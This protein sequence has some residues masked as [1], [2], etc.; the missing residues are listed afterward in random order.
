MRSR[1]SHAG[2][3][4]PAAGVNFFR[5]LSAEFAGSSAKSSWR[6]PSPQGR[7]PV[8]RQGLT[9]IRFRHR[10]DDPVGPGK[11]GKYI[12]L[13]LR[14]SGIEEKLGFDRAKNLAIA[15]G[16]L[17]GQF[18]LTCFRQNKFSGNRAALSV[19]QAASLAASYLS[20]IRISLLH[21]IES[22][23]YGWLSVDRGEIQRPNECAAIQ[24]SV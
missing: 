6:I 1:Q 5:S 22:N 12:A 18:N 9:E 15:G 8:P 4:S 20:R 2:R 17:H 23:V 21:L 10:A 14:P 19:G 16:W 3:L 24:P 13:I 11:F 7:D